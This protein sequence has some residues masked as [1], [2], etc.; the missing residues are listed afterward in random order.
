M[1]ELKATMETLATQF[2]GM[3]DMSKQF[4]A[5]QTMMVTTLDKLSDLEAW[6]SITETSMGSMMQLSKETTKR[7]QQLEARP[8]PPP[9]PPPL[10]QPSAPCVMQPP[11]PPM[12]MPNPLVIFAPPPRWFDLNNIPMASHHSASSS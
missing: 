1:D 5:L 12:M 4:D 3:K 8:P 2:V 9:L 10:P 11:P 6:H 7:V